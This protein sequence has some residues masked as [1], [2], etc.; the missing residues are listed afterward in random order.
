M[1]IARKGLVLIAVL[2]IAQSVFLITLV[3]VRQE[4]PG[5]ESVEADRPAALKLRE[6]A[7]T[8]QKADS[9]R[10]AQART[11]RLLFLGLLASAIVA[12]GLAILLQ[13]RIIRR[14]RWL[15]NNAAPI[16]ENSPSFSIAGDDELIEGG[17]A[18]R[19]ARRV[20]PE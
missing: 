13:T 16:H 15:R 3:A 20:A 18:V 19:E 17:A 7:M 14:L 5:S 4:Q 10:E 11:E 12:L 9:V 2:L 8:A 6:N 1:T